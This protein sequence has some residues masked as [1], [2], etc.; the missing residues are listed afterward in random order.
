MGLLVGLGF[1]LGAGA[2]FH[3]AVC[4]TNWNL[5]QVGACGRWSP[6]AWGGLEA[7][8][9]VS[10]FGLAALAAYDGR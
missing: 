10:L 7:E 8:L 6:G 4:A 1:D 5:V 3:G 9:G 2:T